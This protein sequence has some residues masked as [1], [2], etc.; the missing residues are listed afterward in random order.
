MKSLVVKKISTMLENINIENSDDVFDATMSEWDSLSEDEKK[1]LMVAFN[2]G[3]NKVYAD[4]DTPTEMMCVICHIVGHTDFYEKA[5]PV[6]IEVS[7][8]SKSPLP[9]ELGV[10]RD[11][12]LKFGKEGF[13]VKAIFQIFLGDILKGALADFVLGSI[14]PSGHNKE[15][16]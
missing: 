5:I 15:V 6:Q 11:G 8:K 16:N 9:P 2:L 12:F 4:S 10:F 1:D 3:L 7:K 14:A 13:C